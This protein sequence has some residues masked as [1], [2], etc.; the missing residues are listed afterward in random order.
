MLT[1]LISVLF[2]FQHAHD[3]I[4]SKGPV[5]LLHMSNL[6]SFCEADKTPALLPNAQI[7]HTQMF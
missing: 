5:R 7:L 4:P 1:H 2:S 6:V 3:K